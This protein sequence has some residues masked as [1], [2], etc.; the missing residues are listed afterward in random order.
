M[1][2]NLFYTFLLLLFSLSM[3]AQSAVTYK[4]DSGQSHLLGRIERADLDQPPYQSWFDS[5]YQDYQI[6]KEALHKLN[7]SYKEGIQIKIFLGTWCG[8][9]KREVSRFFKVLDASELDASNV[10]L[11]CL[12]DRRET[13][14]Q[15]PNGDEKGLNIHRV[16]TF[17]FYE[18]EEEIGRIVEHPVTSLEVDMAQIYM[19]IPSTPNYQLANQIGQL[20]E[21]M[22]VAEVD[23]FLNQNSDDLKR[24]VHEVYELSTYGFVLIAAGE[25]EKAK[26]VFQFNSKLFPDSGYAMYGLGR[27]FMLNTENDEAIECFIKAMELGGEYGYS[28][29]RIKEIMAMQGED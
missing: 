22:T 28:K 19:G 18:N 17:I 14:K 26:V 10:S 24:K 11:I 13:Y 5:I 3:S 2:S 21:K 15:S 25:L 1:K 4:N 12:D 27:A 9:S 20:F 8:D 29:M 16:P 23:T 7:A 6:D